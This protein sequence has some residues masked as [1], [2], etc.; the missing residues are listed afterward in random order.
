MLPMKSYFL[1]PVLVWLA[2]VA[3]VRSALAGESGNLVVVEL[4]TSQGCSSCPPADALLHRLAER[5]DVLPLALHVDYWDYI[6]WEDAFA[7]PEH[8]IRQKAYARLAGSRTIYTPQMVIGGI[9]QIV[10]AR[11]MEVADELT[12]QRGWVPG[13]D[14]DVD[15]DDDALT[16]SA[17]GVTDVVGPVLVQ[18]VRFQP[19]EIVEIHQGENAGKTITYSNVVTDWKVLTQWDGDAPLNLEVPIKGGDATAVILQD[20]SDGRILAAERV[21]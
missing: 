5:D 19:E 7:R 10:G 13:A 14:L 12:E 20:E 4:F 1:M 9:A 17:S 3:G 18:L 8:T 6:G 21:E 2:A 15:L 16:I 11:P